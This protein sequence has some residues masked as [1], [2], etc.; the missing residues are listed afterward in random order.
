M[1]I[2]PITKAAALAAYKKADKSGKQLLALLFGEK[3]FSEKITDRVKSFEDACEIKGISPSDVLPYA[4][5]QNDFQQ[6]LNGIAMT[7]VIVEVINE[8]SIPD[9]GNPKQD[10]WEIR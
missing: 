6:A 10:K 1:E 8:G 5:P 4:N 7:W 2:L 9:Y 3:T